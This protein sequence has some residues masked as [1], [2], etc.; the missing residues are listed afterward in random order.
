[1]GNTHCSFCSTPT[2]I[3]NYSCKYKK[4]ICNDCINYIQCCAHCNEWYTKN[5]LR[6]NDKLYCPWCIN[7]F[8]G[9]LITIPSYPCDMCNKKYT[10]NM[11]THDHKLYCVHCIEK[12]SDMCQYVNKKLK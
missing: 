12:I 11:I 8:H 1:M 10:T 2:N 9:L 7:R 5:L 4:N 3:T 6:Y